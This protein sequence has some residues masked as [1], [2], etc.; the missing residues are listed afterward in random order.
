MLFNIQQ[1]TAKTFIHNS[2]KKWKFKI[3]FHNFLCIVLAIGS[4]FLP[5]SLNDWLNK[6]RIEF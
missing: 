2:V 5:K 4:E 6:E 3:P 1:C